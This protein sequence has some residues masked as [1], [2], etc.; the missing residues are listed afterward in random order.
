MK[1]SIN[2]K[3]LKELNSLFELASPAELRED[4]TSL[5]FN[6]IGISPAETLPPNFKSLSENIFFL[7][8]FLTEAEKSQLT[9]KSLSK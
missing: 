3:T 4:L 7:L 8:R 6:F 5:Y 1:N 2:P 9:K